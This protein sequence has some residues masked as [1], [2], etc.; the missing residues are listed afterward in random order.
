LDGK[1]QRAGTMIGT[2]PLTHLMNGNYL[3]EI[4]NPTH[5]KFAKVLKV[6]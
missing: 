3:L 6:D 4:S 2:I 1:I 5:K